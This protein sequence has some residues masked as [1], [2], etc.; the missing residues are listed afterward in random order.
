MMTFFIISFVNTFVHIIPSLINGYNPGLMT[1]VLLFTPHNLCLIFIA[2]KEKKLLKRLFSLFTSGIL[3][4][5]IL[6]LGVQ[7]IFND[8]IGQNMMLLVEVLNAFVINFY[9]EM[10]KNL[11]KDKTNKY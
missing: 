11:F 4:H 6:F 1:S 3:C 10:T 5:F 2:L 8:I 9:F 7:L